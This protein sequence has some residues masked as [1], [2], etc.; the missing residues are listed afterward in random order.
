MSDRNTPQIRPMVSLKEYWRAAAADLGLRLDAPFSI[1]LASGA[2]LEAVAL[3]WCFGAAR[4]MVIVSNF[5]VVRPHEAELF[6]SGFGFSTMSDPTDPYERGGCLEIL[7]DW[8]WSG[9][10][11]DHPSWL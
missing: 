11:E 5:D 9:S 7:R 1:R 10:S 3:L 8:G 4:G 2:T 6:E